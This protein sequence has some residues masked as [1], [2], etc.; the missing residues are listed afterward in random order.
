M[1]RLSL[2]HQLLTLGLLIAALCLPGRAQTFQGS[3]VGTVS[4]PTGA[5]IPGAKV[6]VREQDKGYDRSVMT[7]P[8]GSYQLPLLQPGR[9]RI[10]V[11]KHGFETAARGPIVLTVDQHPRV[12]FM[13]KL[14][15]QVAALT[16]EGAPV[17]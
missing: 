2:P 16:V 6:T 15:T 4:D 14:G 3:F 5:V 17:A 12:D 9:Y 13:L 10:T 7:A 1:T 11:E 8:D